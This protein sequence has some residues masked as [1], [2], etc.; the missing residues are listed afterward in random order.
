LLLTEGTIKR[1]RAL[2]QILQKELT[3]H[4]KPHIVRAPF[5][6]PETHD[7]LPPKDHS[8]SAEAYSLV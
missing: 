7:L 4:G 6:G 2:Q 1:Q 8:G 5:T 3:F